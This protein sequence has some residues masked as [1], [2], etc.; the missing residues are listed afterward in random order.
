MWIAKALNTL[1]SSELEAWRSIQSQR[2]APL[3]QTLG[4]A[5][6]LQTT[7][8]SVYLVFSPDEGVGGVLFDSGSA[9]ECIN[10]PVLD[11]Q[12]ANRCMRQMATFV[13]AASRFQSSASQVVLQPRW[14]LTDSIEWLSHIPM[15]P[16][17]SEVAST[18]ILDTWVD[19]PTHWGRDFSKRLQRTL[20]LTHQAGVNFRWQE[21]RSE[22]DLEDFPEKMRSFGKQKG[23]YVPSRDWFLKLVTGGEGCLQG[24]LACAQYSNQNHRAR[25]E[26]FVGV[27][28]QMAYFLFGCESREGNVRSSMSPSAWAHYQ[29]GLRVAELGCHHY[30]LNGFVRESAAKSGHTYAGVCEFKKQFGGQIVD[31]FSPRWVIDL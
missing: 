12:D 2:A 18:L 22:D 28:G 29:T 14:M 30:D 27:T 3:A 8:A 24:Y 16:F 7:G 26:I 5:R 13:M 11:W 1:D 6:A 4:W 21:V 25:S 15:E 9:L 10:G 20:R 17:S 31:Y 23:F 19:D